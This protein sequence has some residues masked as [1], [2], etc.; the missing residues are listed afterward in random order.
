MVCA[1]SPGGRSIALEDALGA[2][3]IAE[4]ALRLDDSLEPT[5][6]ARF[7][8]DAFLARRDDLAQALADARHGAELI[9]AGFETDVEYCAQLDVSSIV[10]LLHRGADGLLTLRPL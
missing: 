3:A 9:E 10:P 5:D 7:A 8:R 6:A 1:A 4:A 2:G